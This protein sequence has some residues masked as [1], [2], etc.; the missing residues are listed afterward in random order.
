MSD[1][2]I[3]LDLSKEIQQLLADNKMS[4]AD[5]LQNENIEVSDIIEGV[6]P[7]ESEEGARTKDVVPII[8]ASSAAVAVIGFTIS[9]LLNTL[10]LPGGSAIDTF[11]VR[12]SLTEG[13][14]MKF[15]SEVKGT[16]TDQEGNS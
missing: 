9:N 5:I 16:A 7:Q 2:K 10:Q 6:M 1:T 13:I 14:F 11:E 4:I 8:L 12:F 3:Y 15:R